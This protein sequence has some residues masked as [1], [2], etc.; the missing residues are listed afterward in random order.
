MKERIW[1]HRVASENFNITTF[2]HVKMDVPFI[3]SNGQLDNEID[4]ASK[5]L[6]EA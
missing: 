6:L 5:G 2:D 1:I 3:G 4:S